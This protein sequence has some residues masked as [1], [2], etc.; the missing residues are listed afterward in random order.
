MAA[1]THGSARNW[2]SGR[3]LNTWSWTR[4]CITIE[5][6]LRGQNLRVLFVTTEMD[7]F[8]RVGGLA[9]VSAALPRALRPWADVRVLLPGYSDV[10]E[11]LTHIQ[12]VGECAAR[13]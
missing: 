4:S 6:V 12:V 8:V 9:A 3:G 1:T 2:R 7:D 11:Q 13:A 10:I 5:R